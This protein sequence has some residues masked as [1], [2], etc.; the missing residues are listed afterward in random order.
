[1]MTNVPISVMTEPK[2]FGEALVVNRL[3]RLRIV[4]DAKTGIARTPRVVIFERERL[5]I[6]V[7]I[8]A[9]FEQRLQSDLHEK[10][11]RD[12][13]D[14]PPEQVESRPVPETEEQE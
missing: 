2:I 9:Q 5:E 1:M 12:S 13:I 3:D 4:G 14:D 10:V 8:G 11:I 6:R 7:K